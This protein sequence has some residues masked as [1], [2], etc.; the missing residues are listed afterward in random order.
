MIGNDGYFSGDPTFIEMQ[1]GFWLEDA[2][3]GGSIICPRDGR[4]GCALVDWIHCNE[5]RE[6]TH[7]L[8]W[9]WKYR[10][11]QVRSALGMYQVKTSVIPEQVGVEWSEGRTIGLS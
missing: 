5:R 2:P 7:F 6:Q 8:S 11:H 3:L 10:L 1:S 4:P 9:T